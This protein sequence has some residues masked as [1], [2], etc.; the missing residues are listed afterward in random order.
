MWDDERIGNAR[1]WPRSYEE[2]LTAAK[3]L[4]DSPK[5]WEDDGASSTSSKTSLNTRTR[6][7]EISEEQYRVKPV[8]LHKIRDSS[9]HAERLLADY[10]KHLAQDDDCCYIYEAD[11]PENLRGHSKER[12]HQ[13]DEED[14]LEQ[15]RMDV[16]SESPLST[17][18]RKN[19]NDE[20]PK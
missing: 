1:P 4:Y 6:L 9:P 12:D 16:P 13:Q 15:E 11:H 8:V 10:H 7:M 20:S 14:D 5:Y 17:V 18:P 3:T 19:P 2:G